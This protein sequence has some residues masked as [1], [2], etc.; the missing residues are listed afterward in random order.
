[1]CLPHAKYDSQKKT[2]QMLHASNHDI[3][4]GQTLSPECCDTYIYIY[5]YMYTHTH[6]HIH[7][8]IYRER[9]R[10]RDRETETERERER[11]VSN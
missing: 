7:T 11:E 1:M 8:Y 3:R 2:F 5:I 9:E 10:Y 4:H 6:I